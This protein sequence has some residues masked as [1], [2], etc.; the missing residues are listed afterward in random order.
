MLSFW[1]SFVRHRPDIIV[2]VKSELDAFPPYAYAAAKLSGMRRIVAIER[3]IGDARGR[4]GR[5]RGNGHR[6]SRLDRVGGWL[7]QRVTPLTRPELYC[8]TIVCIGHS[9]REQLVRQF[10]YPVERLDVVSNGVD[11]K[12]FAGRNGTGGVR[13]RWNLKPDDDVVVS[14]GRLDEASG[15]DVLL[16]ALASICPGRPRCK[17]LVV[18]SGSAESEFRAQ[19]RNLGLSAHVTFTGYVTDVKSILH[20]SDIFVSP[21]RADRIRRAALEAMASGLPCVVTDACGRDGISHGDDGIV[22]K[23]GSVPELAGAIRYLLR[24]RQE[25]LRI[26]DNARRTVQAGFSIDDTV[27]ELIRIMLGPPAVARGVRDGLWGVLAK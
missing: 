19:A 5:T 8:D 14:V 27:D 13:D 22:V 6:T 2:F 7:G 3:K 26:G 21:S 25:R 16:Q 10:D 12:E 11:V 20:S 18:G 23:A 15:V 1:Q 17:C 9:L 24:D 4:L